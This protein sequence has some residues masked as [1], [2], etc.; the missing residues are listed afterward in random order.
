MDIYARIV[1][2]LLFLLS[3][4]RAHSLGRLG[5]RFGLPWRL[6]GRGSRFRSPRLSTT[7]AGLE[8]DNPIGLAPGLESP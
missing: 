2:P 1:R 5:L 4:D 6:L 8:L 7:I 3:A